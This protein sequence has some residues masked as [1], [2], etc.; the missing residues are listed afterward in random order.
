MLQHS[1]AGKL[2][3]MWTSPD[4]GV[5][6]NQYLGGDVPYAASTQPMGLFAVP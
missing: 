5:G 6:E 1:A 2:W 3:V 4:R